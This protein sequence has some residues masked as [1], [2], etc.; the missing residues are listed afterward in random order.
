MIL[1]S[2]CCS[3]YLWDYV[4]LNYSMFV[5]GNEG[6]CRPVQQCGLLMCF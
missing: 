2:R 5:E 3:G 4:K 6:T 1:F